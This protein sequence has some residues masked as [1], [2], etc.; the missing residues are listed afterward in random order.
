MLANFGF[1]LNS[2]QVKCYIG[3]NDTVEVWGRGKGSLWYF[4]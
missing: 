2:V 1:N 4:Y 3:K